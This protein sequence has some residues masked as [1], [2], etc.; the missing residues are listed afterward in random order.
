MFS[1]PIRI[2]YPVPYVRKGLGK[3]TLLFLPWNSL[4]ILVIQINDASSTD[5][6]PVNTTIEKLDDKTASLGSHRY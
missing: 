6:L 4:A 1:M 5:K 2:E 3:T